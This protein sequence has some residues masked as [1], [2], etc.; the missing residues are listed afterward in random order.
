[1]KKTLS[2]VLMSLTAVPLF[3][4][5][6]L[7][8]EN[9]ESFSDGPTTRAD[10]SMTRLPSQ[11]PPHAIDG[12]AILPGEAPQ[13]VIFGY[14]DNQFDDGMTNVLELYK[15]RVNPPGAGNPLTFDG[16]PARASFYVTPGGRDSQWVWTVDEATVVSWKRAFDEGHEIGNHTYYHEHGLQFT[17]ERWS[18][19]IQMCNDFIV[20]RVGIPLEAVT[21]FR[22]PFLEYN[23]NL[24]Y[25]LKEHGFEYDNSYEGGIR[26]DGETGSTMY[27]PYTMDNGAPP[28]EQG[29]TLAKIPGMWEMPT[30]N[31]V[32]PSGGK[33]T[34]F[35]YNLWFAKQYTKAKFVATLKNTL[36]KKYYGNRAPMNFGMHTNYYSDK[37]IEE[38]KIYD[39]ASER[40]LVTNVVERTQGIKE[41][42][43]YALSLPDVRVVTTQQALEWIKYPVKLTTPYV[44]H[45]VTITSTANGVIT[46]APGVHK[47]IN[48]RDFTVTIDA[49]A[50]YEIASVTIDGVVHSLTSNKLE[51]LV[52]KQVT[53]PKN[54][55]V[56]FIYDPAA[57]VYSI[58]AV[59]GAR[60]VFDKEGITRV[61]RGDSI[62]YN[63][64]PDAAWAVSIFK[65]DGVPVSNPVFP[66]T[67]NNVSN[68][69]ELFVDFEYVGEPYIFT[70]YWTFDYNN[71]DVDLTTPPVDILDLK[72]NVIE[73]MPEALAERLAMEGSGFTPLGKLVNLANSYDWPQARFFI[74]DQNLA[75]YGYDSQG[76]PLKPWKSSA[77]DKN[78]IP[79][80]SDIYVKEFDGVKLPDATL[81]NGWMKAVDTSHSFSGK[82][83]DI[84]S[85][86]Y[87]GYQYMTNLLNHI[88]SATVK[89]Q[90]GTQFKITL[91]AGL[92]GMISASL[93]GNH[94]P[95]TEAFVAQGMDRAFVIVP[96]AGYEVASVTVNG[97]PVTLNENSMY[98]FADVQADAVLS[99]TFKEKGVVTLY[100]VTAQ[101]GANGSVDPASVT[102]EAG[103]SA[104]FTI[105]P[106]AGYKVKSVTLDGTAVTAPGNVVHVA[107]VSKNSVLT[108]DFDLIVVGQTYTVTAQ[109]GPNGSVTPS[110]V[111][112]DEGADA[113]FT[114]TP[115][116]G[117][118]VDSVTLDGTP[119]S[120]TGN[121]YRVTGVIKN[122][123]LAVTFKKDDTVVSALSAVYTL[124]PDWG[125]GFSADVVIT[126]NGTTAV[127]SWTVTMTYQGNQKVS[128]W[129]ALFSQSGKVVTVTNTSWN[130]TL[131]PGAS[132]SFGFN[133][134][135]SGVNDIPVISA[136]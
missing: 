110:S 136:Q 114:I 83:I 116:A 123:A 32:E 38:M 91:D 39:P 74:V 1:M 75:P 76:G 98:N 65:I 64:I 87:Q 16:A 124:G 122:M 27:W 101:A 22:T 49:D 37:A 71:E 79:L 52:L 126:N 59:S 102:V 69:M 29:R 45:D 132:T 97:S 55:D 129:N 108:V 61:E 103:Q 96:D 43:D 34:G 56:Q 130:G 84:F 48:H 81:H 90:P 33:V 95:E 44:E 105:T 119:V 120:V 40:K 2:K 31:V 8:V 51:T 112:V 118:L 6:S 12:A 5:C 23:T 57:V 94:T 30:D 111:V 41:F 99:A 70:Y 68:N 67:I 80:N 88:T 35:D 86:D 82:W 46:P 117:Y 125:T 3:F 128:G 107:S 100:T 58:N 7:T 42:L 4:S 18:E 28:G 50:G 93:T 89:F 14:D 47:V 17:V 9:Q 13:F 127:D 10:Y 20:E 26:W 113:V 85:A 11:E 53:A 135:Y 131:A 106:D 109:G 63:V 104:V 19:E 36:D 133:G 24:F 92:N 72:G 134:S 121:T 62:T 66:Y 60:G 54:I 73:T 78:I 21:G 115:D 25:A 77:V 15:T